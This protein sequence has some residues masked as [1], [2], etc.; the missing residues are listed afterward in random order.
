M[1]EI[2]DN[3]LQQRGFSTTYSGFLGDLIN[4]DSILTKAQEITSYTFYNLQQ[5]LGRDVSYQLRRRNKDNASAYVLEALNGNNGASSW[6]AFREVHPR[7]NLD[8]VKDVIQRT[9]SVLS[10]F[11]DL[12]QQLYTSYDQI[13]EDHARQNRKTGFLSRK[14]YELGRKWR[15]R[16]NDIVAPYTSTLKQVE[17]FIKL[18]MYDEANALVGV[19]LG[20]NSDPK[21]PQGMK[22]A[23]MLRAYQKKHPQTT[24]SSDLEQLSEDLSSLSESLELTCIDT[25]PYLIDRQRED[26]EEFVRDNFGTPK[27]EPGQILER[28]H[29]RHFNEIMGYLESQQYRELCINLEK[30]IQEDDSGDTEFVRANKRLIGKVERLANLAETEFPYADAFNFITSNEIVRTAGGKF[31]QVKKRYQGNGGVMIPL[32]N[33][34]HAVF[35]YD[36]KELEKFKAACLR[37]KKELTDHVDGLGYVDYQPTHVSIVY[38]IDKNGVIPGIVPGSAT[39]LIHGVQED[40]PLTL[41]YRIPETV[42]EEIDGKREEIDLNNA[43]YAMICANREVI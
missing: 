43:V 30:W 16:D 28:A 4:S 42:E 29:Y 24:R 19:M 27:K 40:L 7:Q 2:A 23:Q 6:K 12:Y 22:I 34:Q 14:L 33:G 3:F 38:D 21:T 39:V 8:K 15:G 17:N 5:S 11:D 18:G 35:N 26:I 13:A 36:E 20:Y 25:I 31:K 41:E 1:G 10:G 37:L 9:E 32:P